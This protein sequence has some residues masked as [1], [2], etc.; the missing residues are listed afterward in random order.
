M[1]SLKQMVCQLSPKS[2]LEKAPPT[3]TASKE[4]KITLTRESQVCETDHNGNGQPTR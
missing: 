2:H 3:I 4:H 1:R